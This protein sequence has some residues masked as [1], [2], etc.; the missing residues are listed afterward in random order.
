[1]VSRDQD[2]TVVRGDDIQQP[3]T[4]TLDQSRVLDGTESWIFQIRRHKTDASKLVELTSPTEVTID[5]S[6][7]QPTVVFLASTLTIA[8]FPASDVDV[9]YWYDL[10]MTK[11]AKV[12]TVA[13]G[14]LTIITDVSR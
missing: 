1:M 12:E 8:L 4:V 3:F 14:R 5:G 11:S 9:K 10:Q 2:F 6:T 13:E 7:F